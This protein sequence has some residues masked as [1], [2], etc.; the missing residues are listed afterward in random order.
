MVMIH[1]NNKLEVLIS[2]FLSIES[3]LQKI[4]IVSPKGNDSYGSQARGLAKIFR[5]DRQGKKNSLLSSK[6]IFVLFQSP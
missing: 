2:I 4:L 3:S 6:P 5:K 1:N